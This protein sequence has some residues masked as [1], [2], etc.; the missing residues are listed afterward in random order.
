[1]S[2]TVA[3]LVKD[4]ANILFSELSDDAKKLLSNQ[5]H[6]HSP[7]EEGQTIILIWLNALLV[8]QRLY[9]QGVE[10]ISSISQSTTNTKRPN[11]HLNAW[12]SIRERNWR[13]IF[14]PAIDI[15]EVAIKI[16]IGATH[17]ALNAL[18]NSVMEIEC[19]QLGLHISVGAELFPK[20]SEDRE[21]AAQ[22]YTLPATA[23]LLSHLTILESSLSTE[24][25]GDPLILNQ[26]KVADM[27]CGT[28]TL[29]RAGYR[30]IVHLHEK[31]A[32]ERSDISLM[33][34]CAM[35]GGLIGVD[36]SPMAAHLTTSSLASMG[37]GDTYGATQIGWVEVG[38][39]NY[40]T[41]AL[42]FFDKDRIVDIYSISG[43]EQISGKERHAN[44]SVYVPNGSIDWILMNPPYSRAHGGKKPFDLA[45]LTEEETDGCLKRWGK[46]IEK[47][48]AIKTSGM[49]A[50]FL[51]LAELK[52]KRGTGRIGFVLPLTAAF[53]ESWSRTRRMI[54]THFDDI[55]T[56]TV[57]PYNQHHDAMSADT[58]MGEMLLVATRKEEF[59]PNTVAL[60]IL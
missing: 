13:S 27:A 17:R 22:F 14:K 1:V 21:N 5:L 20:L 16:N 18:V 38:G 39:V 4:A 47:R 56:V 26:Y 19:A 33:H 54:E 37:E 31:H 41:G 7:I 32:R 6:R 34:T 9:I 15:L 28:G 46:Q 52:A 45:G 30:R 12:L 36:I 23:E 60:K 53:S 57:S 29:L 55:V 25:W 11:E 49:A 2:Q 8:Q 42:E 44:V 50:S 35:E 51:V 58:G 3:D 10:E 43:V 24:E 59:N 40:K 48:E